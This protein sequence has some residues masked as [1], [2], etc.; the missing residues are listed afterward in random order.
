MISKMNQ[1]PLIM[2]GW[3][4]E[5]FM[6]LRPFGVNSI[7]SNKFTCTIMT[8]T[9]VTEDLNESMLLI[10]F[11]SSLDSIYI[12]HCT[13][14]TTWRIRAEY[15]K[16]F[17]CLNMVSGSPPQHSGSRLISNF[18][19]KSRDCH[20][21][22]DSTKA[23]QLMVIM[24]ILGNM[25]YCLNRLEANMKSWTCLKMLS[26]TSLGAS[27]MPFNRVCTESGCGKVNR[28]RCRNTR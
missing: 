8:T 23:T 12:N 14:V 9:V 17:I 26:F 15:I 13:K 3:L 21:S 10:E 6:I 27:G 5:W 28:Y 24:G 11:I 4:D 7:Y 19:F 20:I 2:K 25:Y 18:K 1:V 16:L 22:Y